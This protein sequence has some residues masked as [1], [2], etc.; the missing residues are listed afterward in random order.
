M[1]KNQIMWTEEEN[2]YVINNYNKFT[3]EKIALHLGRTKDSVK[4]K[5]HK[6]LKLEPKIKG[7]NNLVPLLSDSND[8]WYWLGFIA[9]DGY[10][11][12]NSVSITVHPD[13]CN[14]LEIL[15]NLV[16]RT[17]STTKKGY[18]CLSIGDITNILLLKNKIGYNNSAKTYNPLSINYKVDKDYMLSF[19]FGLIDADGCIEVRNKKMSRLK[20]ECHGSWYENLRL[21]GTFLEINLNIESKTIINKRGYALFTITKHTNGIKLRN[22]LKRLK[23]PYLKR[24]WDGF[25]DST[26]ACNFFDDIEDVVIEKYKNGQNLHSIAKEL[27]VKYGSLYNHKK[28]I[29]TKV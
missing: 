13:D 16:N 19:I 4:S 6:V 9:G 8:V 7:T 12:E 23:I 10:L 21:I 29:L 14:H 26:H 22:E 15:G 28:Y 11:S 24:K 18:C 1:A 27:G 3:Y 25:S 17:T 20:I 5:I 2:K